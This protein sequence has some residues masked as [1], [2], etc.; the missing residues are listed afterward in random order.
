MVANKTN[1]AESTCSNINR[2]SILQH[3][4]LESPRS[5]SHRQL[6]QHFPPVTV[7]FALWRWPSNLIY[8]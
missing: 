3:A 1:K 5:R 6:C 4:I 7:N 8:S 2:K